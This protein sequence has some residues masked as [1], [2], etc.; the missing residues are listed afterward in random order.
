M[1]LFKTML[2]YNNTK[3]F[4]N[5]DC[6]TGIMKCAK[7]GNAIFDC[8]GTDSERTYYTNELYEK[9]MQRI[10]QGDL[11]GEDKWLKNQ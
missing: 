3:I 1:N 2:E 11:L 5:L 8:I 6:V 7:N 9:V 4:I 10:L